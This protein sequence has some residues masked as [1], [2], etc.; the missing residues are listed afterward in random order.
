MTDEEFERLEVLDKSIREDCNRELGSN[1]G[2]VIYTNK[3]LMRLFL[4]HKRNPPLEEIINKVKKFYENHKV[5]IDEARQILD[6]KLAPWEI[7]PG[8]LDFHIAA[9][10]KTNEHES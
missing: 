8:W 6:K 5:T 10:L 3:N 7:Q 4:A 1:L 9:A 2:I